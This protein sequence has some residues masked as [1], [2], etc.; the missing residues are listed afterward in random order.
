MYV[1]FSLNMVLEYTYTTTCITYTGQVTFTD[2]HTCSSTNLCMF[3]AQV[4]LVNNSTLPGSQYEGRVEV[5][6]NG[7]WATVCAHD[8]TYK[9]QR[10][11]V[12]WQRL[13]LLYA[14]SQVDTMTRVSSAI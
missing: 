14:Q 11:C 3:A 4:W 9:M 1:P 12:G 6:S 5:Y 13:Q 2:V 7:E 10:W 8:W